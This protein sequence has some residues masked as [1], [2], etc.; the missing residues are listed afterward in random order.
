MHL[1]APN[2]PGDGLVS[3]TKG[4][5]RKEVI[6]GQQIFVAASGASYE[7]ASGDSETIPTRTDTAAGGTFTD[8]INELDVFT[9][10][11]KSP[12]GDNN[13]T[14]STDNELSGDYLIKRRVGDS[15]YVQL[16]NNY[17]FGNGN[18]FNYGSS[19]A[20]THWQKD[21]ETSNLL[22]DMK[23]YDVIGVQ[24]FAGNPTTTVWADM[25]AKGEVDIKQTDTFTAHLGNIYDFGGHWDYNFGNG[26]EE[27]HMTGTTI[28][29]EDNSSFLE[30]LGDAVADMVGLL[31]KSDMA[32]PPGPG[33]GTIVGELVTITQDLGWVSKSYG[34]SYDY[35]D[36]NTIEVVEGDAE[37]H[38]HG[39]TYSKCYG[40]SVEHF[41]GT[42]HSTYWGA[43]NDMFMGA[44]SEFMVGA[45][46][47]ISLAATNDIFVGAKSDISIAVANNMFIGLSFDLTMG[48]KCTIDTAV[49]LK[50][51]VVEIDS[52]AVAMKAKINAI[53]TR[54]NTINSALNCIASGV[55]SID[56]YPMLISPA[57]LKLL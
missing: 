23:A 2:H 40:D 38:F 53:C 6:G 29:K 43:S 54:V 20:L 10:P 26:Y 15:Y 30:T 32:K 14:L 12:T 33:W 36:G 48:G 9:F 7:N 39:S 49:E 35:Y 47:S 31:A 24:P 21:G 37:S 42:S 25:L 11:G 55:V 34:D 8:V 28:H 3:M 45:A 1:G 22:S 57:G 44:S 52:A 56:N 27:N 13:G 5:E 18:E 50:T 4:I 46:S 16:G 17:N 19:Q 51:Q 41:R